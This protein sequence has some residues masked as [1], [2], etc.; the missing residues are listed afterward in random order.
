MSSIL[1]FLDTER[2]GF[3]DFGPQQFVKL[4]GALLPDRKNDHLLFIPAGILHA[5]GDGAVDDFLRDAN[6]VQESG[7]SPNSKESIRAFDYRRGC[8]YER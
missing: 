2:D 7:V 5:L 8:R 1:S 6:D 3:V 4:L